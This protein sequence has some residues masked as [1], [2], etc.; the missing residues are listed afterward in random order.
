MFSKL[1]GNMDIL[2]TAL[3]G[4]SLRYEAISNNLANVN[5]PNYKRTTVEFENELQKVISGE[6]TKLT[7]TKTHDKHMGKGK[8]NI[9]N[10]EPTIN[11]I[12]NISTRK[13]KNNVNPD[14]EMIDM[15]KTIIKYN[16]LTDQ[17]SRKF[18][19]IQNVIS[20]GGK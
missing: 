11:K 9:E 12:N 18:N 4:S 20:E 10:F 19:G 15:A 5:T 7:L 17:I 13:D 14:I 6:N 8:L 16:A 3:D 1:Y 2:K